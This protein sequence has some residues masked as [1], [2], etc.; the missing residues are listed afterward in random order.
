MP[1]SDQSRAAA[2][3][4]RRAARQDPPRPAPRCRPARPPARQLIVGPLRPLHR[5]L[6]GTFVRSSVII[7]PFRPSLSSACQADVDT[8]RR[9]GRG[10][11]RGSPASIPWLD[12]PVNLRMF[13]STW[14]SRRA[15]VAVHDVQP[16]SVVELG[17]LQ[18][19]CRIELAMGRGRGVEDFAE[20]PLDLVVV[21]EDLS[22]GSR[23]PT[24]RFANLLS[25]RLVYL[26]L[27]HGRKPR[28][29]PDSRP[30]R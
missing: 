7:R 21:V 26:H 1:F 15:L 18:P 14:P 23:L 10:A 9:V 11:S 20:R 25:V 30:C 12:F 27:A 3:S 2:W 5:L 22:R 29:R 28:G 4:A 17:V 16:R 19:S 8:G 6:A 24:S 13:S